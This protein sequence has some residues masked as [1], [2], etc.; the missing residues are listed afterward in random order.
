MNILI[1]GLGEVGTHLARALSAQKHR[2]TVID[3]DLARLERIRSDKDADCTTV[4]GDGS[5]PDVLDRADAADADLLLAV[6]ND[7]NANMLSCL[8]GKRIGA[9]QTVLRVKDMTPFQA[10]RT[11]FRKNLEFDYVLSLEELAA[12]EIVKTIRQNKAVGV[13]NFAE[14]KIQLRRLRLDASSSMVG[15]K[16]RDMKSPDGMLV[17]AIDRA[18]E[19][20]IPSG[21]DMFLEGDEVLAIGEPKSIQA[22]ES[23]AGMKATILRNIAM[24]GSTGVVRQVYERLKAHPSV[25]MMK[26]I[27][28]DEEEADQM[29]EW[30]RTKNAGVILGDATDQ[31]MLKEEVG[32]YDVFL[33]L[34]DVDEMNLMTCQLARKIG[35][36]RTVALVHKRDYVAI[37]QELGVTSAVSPRLLCAD[38][39]VSFV[40]KGSIST[41]ATI[42]E[43]KA[44]VIEIEIQRGS[45]LV[46]RRVSELGLPRGVMIGAIAREDGHVVVP[47]GDT[48][49]RA[50]DNLVI[51]VLTDVMPKLMDLLR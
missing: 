1:V 36:E 47:R 30:V 46:G 13:E 25:K 19:V 40:R 32:G 21:D 17:A 51:F 14:G 35:I 37:Y 3:P 12:T 28:A 27:A 10:F 15:Q 49:I 23:R 38:A 24:F 2:V 20:I 7:D 42:E 43:G 18:H 34:S 45:R 50:L 6:S 41:I 48:E 5:R 16:V 44:E 8:F 4:R 33:G 39:I 11:F 9:K 29:A 26:I 22:F 31:K